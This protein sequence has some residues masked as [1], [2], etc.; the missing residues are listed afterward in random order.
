MA[1]EKN[2]TPIRVSTLR[3]DLKIP[4]GVYI[5]VAGKYILYIRAGDSFE[6]RR[7][8]RLKAKKL[9]KMFVRREDEIPYA[10]YLEQS[11]DAAYDS[12]SGKALEIRTEV[13]QG[14][15]QAAAEEYMENPDDRSCYNHVSSSAQR[16]VEFIEREP[17]AAGLLLKMNNSD[18]SITHHSVN[19]AALT[20]MMTLNSKMKETSKLHLLGLGCL[21]H[22]YEH[23]LSETDL[24]R[25]ISSFSK[26]EL[27]EYREHPIRGGRRLQR[28][29]FVDQIVM[30]V[31][32]QHEELVDGSGFPKGLNE[33]EIEPVVLLAATANAFDRLI[34]F[35]NMTPKEAIKFILIDKMGGLPLEHLQNLQTVLKNLRII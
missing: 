9:R 34:S 33:K 35:E 23:Y 26:S 4:F 30:N 14:F 8:D 17:T 31:V 13:I 12:K 27:A 15:Q 32:T 29:P 2:Y 24:S 10:Q 19:V 1:E 16:F 3:G 21:L 5:K 6:G 18:F 25:P 11:I 22:D 20:V 28:L 7:L